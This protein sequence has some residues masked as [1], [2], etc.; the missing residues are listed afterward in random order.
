MELIRPDTRIDF[1]SRRSLF[2]GISLFFILI[3][4]GAFFWPGPNWGIDFKGGT[5]IRVRFLKPVSIGELRDVVE[6]M[7]LGDTQIQTI[8]PLL[9]EQ[10]RAGND[11]LI[12][13]EKLVT[14]GA[15]AQGEKTS[16]GAH[17]IEERLNEKFGKD[18]F[19]M[20]SV[21]YVGPRVGRELKSR[22]VQALIFS[23]IG[24]LIYVGLRF[25]FSYGI[26]ALASLIHDA[27][28]TAGFYVIFQR[29]WSLSIIAALLTMI[30][31]SVN[32]T[33]VIYDRIRENIRRS[34]KGGLHEIVNISINETLSR[35]LLTN[36]T[37]MTVVVILFIL[38][39]GIIRDFSLIF[40]VGGITGTYSTIYIASSIVLFVEELRGKKPAQAGKANKP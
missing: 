28:I 35:T 17:L 23:L 21:N 8:Q 5:E 27:I 11:Y 39:Q 2:F 29:E 24:I 16:K 10:T 7:K 19:Q 22:G 36:F 40:I 1:V 20:L 30:G 13:V 9:G 14:E 6:A 26:G 34:R 31:Y 33:V 3:S 18:S 25:E 15:E 4:I 38:N 37:V 32:D 12:R